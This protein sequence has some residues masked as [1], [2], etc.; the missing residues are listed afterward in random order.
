MK[1]KDIITRVD[2]NPKF[3]REVDL[4]R[5]SDNMETG[6]PYYFDWYSIQGERFTS[7][8]ISSWYCTDTYVGTVIYFFDDE[9]FAISHQSGRKMS[10]EF[11]FFS[12]EVF[13]KAKTYLLSLCQ[14][15]ESISV[16]L[17][18]DEEF[19]MYYKIRSNAQL[20]DYHKDI[21]FYLGEKVKIIKYKQKA[22]SYYTDSEVVIQYEDGEK[23]TVD[24][25]DLDF[26]YNLTE[27]I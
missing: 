17:D 3:K 12:K 15:E 6:I 21:P 13:D 2:K 23:K 20:F 4:E 11:E 27:Y 24:I 18:L 1:L 9:P 19:P 16:F 5:L 25:S 22:N 10:E 7:Y 14:K 8:F 26:P